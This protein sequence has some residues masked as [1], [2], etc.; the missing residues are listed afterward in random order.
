[1]NHKKSQMTSNYRNVQIIKMSGKACFDDKNGMVI[2][3]I[4]LPFCFFAWL[5]LF[6]SSFCMYVV[7]SAKNILHFHLKP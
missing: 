3:E 5:I 6:S 2:G 1:M 7:V 4:F